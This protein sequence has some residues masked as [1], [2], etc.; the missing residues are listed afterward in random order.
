[1]NPTIIGYYYHD[2]AT[3]LGTRDLVFWVIRVFPG[4]LAPPPTDMAN[5]LKMATIETIWTL[6]ERGW[7]QLRIAKEPGIN[8]ETVARY[9]NSKPPDSKLATNAPSHFAPV[10]CPISS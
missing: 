9:L 6:K 5:Q 1:L 3:D 2:K 8:H 4:I 7:S 10:E